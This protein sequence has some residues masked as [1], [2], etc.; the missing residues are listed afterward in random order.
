[1]R[2]RKLWTETEVVNIKQWSNT[3]SVKQIA[4]RLGRTQRSVETKMKRLGVTMLTQDRQS[5]P[6]D[7]I[8]PAK[9]AV[10]R[11]LYGR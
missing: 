7:V 1:M 11:F 4:Q 3:A 8:S 5:T 2:T 6:N 10:E 9:Q